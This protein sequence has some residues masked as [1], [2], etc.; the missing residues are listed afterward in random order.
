[1]STA[2]ELFDWAATGILQQGGFC[3][4][5]LGWP[6]WQSHDRLCAMGWV[7]KYRSSMKSDNPL[8]IAEI[9]EAIRALQEH[10]DLVRDLIVAHDLCAALGIRNGSIEKW[11]HSMRLIAVKH[12]LSDAVLGQRS[13]TESLIFHDYLPAA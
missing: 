13:N 6:A 3:V 11:K 4:Q 2:Q 1:M 9:T 8:Q 10:H 7:I 12:N 5:P